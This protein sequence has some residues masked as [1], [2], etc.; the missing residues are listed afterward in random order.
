MSWL[1]TVAPVAALIAMAM[2][3]THLLPISVSLYYNDGM[4]GALTLSM[5]LNFCAGAILW[6]LTRRNKR[7]LSLREG[8]LLV[9]AVWA[10]GSLFASLPLLLTV[11][12]LSFT[13]AYFEAVSGLTATG[14]TVISG[15]EELPASINVWRAVLQWLGGMGV[16]VLVVAILPMLGVGGRQISK[17]E[18]PGPMKDEQLTPRIAQTAKGLWLIY[19]ALTIA[20]GFAYH[21]AGMSPLDALIHSFTTMS[22]GGFSSYD[23]SLG[24]FNSATVEL[25]AICFM[26]IAGIN[27]S[28]HFLVWRSRS[29]MTYARDTEARYFALVIVASVAG[30]AM[31]LYGS[32]T[33][34]DPLTALRYAAFNIISVGTT[35]GYSTTDYTLWPAFAPMWILFIGTFLSCSG[36]TGGGIKMMRAVILYRQVYRE[37]KSLAHPQ[38]VSPVKVAGHVVADSVVFAV[39]AFFFVWIAL[40]VTMTLILGWTGLDPVTA[41][42]AVVATL[43]NIGPGLHR[44]GPATNFSVLTDLQTWVCAFAMLLGRLEL[45]ALLVIFTP[46]F[47]RK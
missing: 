22:L 42:S 5:A 47:W 3:L 17:S 8:I 4:A 21:A 28:T 11:P 35:T 37:I 44:V 1:L 25:V 40:L 34:T 24:H 23:A 41:F 26:V 38:A 20:C 9:V 14:A 10:G 39:L 2:S 46:A 32:G 27:F 16:I 7:E 29:L 15:L 13:D 19:A 43:N 18:I 6:L 30:V 33:Y 45:F 12:Q 36:S 31:L